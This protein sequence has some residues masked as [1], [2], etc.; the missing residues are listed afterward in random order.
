LFV[1]GGTIS[2][3]KARVT[4]PRSFRSFSQ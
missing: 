1:H 4:Y 3:R 2:Y